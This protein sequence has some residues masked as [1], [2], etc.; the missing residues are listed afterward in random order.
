MG[1][2]TITQSIHRNELTCYRRRLNP[3]GDTSSWNITNNFRKSD[4]RYIKTLLC[5]GDGNA[6]NSGE[7][8]NKEEV[9]EE[10]RKQE[11]KADD[12][13]FARDHNANA[14]S[15]ACTAYE[16]EKERANKVTDRLK[17]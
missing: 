1:G 16:S 17:K 2:T 7:F 11:A 9:D 5:N 4:G 3:D 14:L 6:S 10:R 13:K 15:Q 12:L 8:I